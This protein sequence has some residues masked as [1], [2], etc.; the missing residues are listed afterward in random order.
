MIIPLNPAQIILQTAAMSP[1][2]TPKTDVV[3]GSVRVYHINGVGAEVDDLIAT[4]LVRVGVT[5]I[6]RYQWKPTSLAVG[7]YT[8]QYSLVDTIAR[9]FSGLEDI[10][11]RDIAT[12][13]DL[14]IVKKIETGRWKIVANQMLFYDDDG[15]TVLYT[16]DLKDAAGSPSMTSVFERIIAP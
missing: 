15:V 12:Q 3:S 1:D 10:F 4:A 16:F 13:T 14:S 8:A 2:G 7:D 11:V 5:N 9:T 6:W